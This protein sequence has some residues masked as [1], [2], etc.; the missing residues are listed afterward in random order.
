MEHLVRVRNESDRK[1]LSWLR[2]R[3]GEAALAEAVSYFA[4]PEKPYLS[5]LCRQLG[6]R[7]PWTI[8]ACGPSDSTRLEVGEQ[9][10]TA[11][12]QILSRPRSN[13][14]HAHA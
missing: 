6:V 7:P 12:R 14:P 10:L 3:V 11:I 4:G 1:L 9:H 5:Q 8:R 13:A 2:E